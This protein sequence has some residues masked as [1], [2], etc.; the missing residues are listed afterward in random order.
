[1]GGRASGTP[2]PRRI[3]IV[4]DSEDTRLIVS[5]HFALA[6]YR[7]EVAADGNEGVAAALRLRPDV[8]VLDVVMPV[9]DGVSALAIL[10][11]YP[12]T[13]ATPVVICTGNPEALNGRIVRYDAIV[14]KPY[15]PDDLERAIN[16]VL[17][18]APESNTA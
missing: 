6:G 3:L 14:R 16:E 9:L 7:V 1:M 15:G 2:L 8:I 10:R 18:D 4:E 12:T 17:R 5:E 13:L 11:S